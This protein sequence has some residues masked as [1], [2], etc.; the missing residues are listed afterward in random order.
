MTGKDARLI[1]GVA[2]GQGALDGHGALGRFK[3]YDPAK[4]S[5]PDDGTVG[6]RTQ[7]SRDKTRRDGGGGAAR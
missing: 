4:G 6:L 3:A 1:K 5:R 7:G 2:E